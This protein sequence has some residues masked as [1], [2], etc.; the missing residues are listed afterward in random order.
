MVWHLKQ[1]FSFISPYSMKECRKALTS[2]ESEQSSIKLLELD[3][4]R[5]EILCKIGRHYMAGGKSPAYS[6]VQIH[7]TEA[8]GG[9]SVSGFAKIFALQ[10]A[11]H[12]YAI[13]ITFAF[14]YA[15]RSILIAA[16]IWLLGTVGS[17]H[18]LRLV[19]VNRQLLIEEVQEMLEM[20]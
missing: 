17:V 15:F 5:G 10:V 3:D 4:K 9:V 19:F 14:A 20:E 8:Q 7:L 1:P 12:S 2:L 11:F 16:L 18:Y 6:E 13:I